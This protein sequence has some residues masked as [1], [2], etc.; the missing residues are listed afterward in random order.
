MKIGFFLIA[1]SVLF[2]FAGIKQT[3][4]EDNGEAKSVGHW[5][6]SFLP[7]IV[8]LILGLK[9]SKKAKDETD[10]LSVPVLDEEPEKELSVVPKPPI[11]E[12]VI[13]RFK[14]ASNDIRYFA[15][16][17]ELELSEWISA[18]QKQLHEVKINLS[19]I[20]IDEKTLKISVPEASPSCTLVIRD[21]DPNIL[22]R[23]AGFDMAGTSEDLIEKKFLLT[24]DGNREDRAAN[25]IY[26]MLTKCLGPITK[27]IMIDVELEYATDDWISWG[28]DY[29]NGDMFEA[30]N[31]VGLDV[32]Y[33]SL[34][35]EEKKKWNQEFRNAAIY[36]DL[37]SL[38]KFLDDDPS[39]VNEKDEYGFT[40]LHEAVGEHSVETI[41]LLLAA[42]ADVNI[43]NDDEITPLHLVAYDYIAE[44]LLDAG[45]DIESGANSV[46][47]PLH[48]HAAEPESNEVIEILLKRGA[49]KL[50]QNSN[51]ETP[52]DIAQSR[53]EFDKVR[54]FSKY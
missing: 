33:P 13:S 38:K 31:S 18:I 45:A 48:T 22:D 51:G 43:K 27:G 10:S 34:R 37:D 8:L 23:L 24:L 26:N 52:V 39:L 28:Y 1:L 3:F 11:E 9:F 49:N 4:L 17:N 40:A 12:C 35:Y 54:L 6:G 50:A 36:G 16:D 21:M 2:A 32:Q 20:E 14:P 47:T 5:V 7:C 46:G 44:A 30:F 19:F 53:Q 25:F 42:G 15:V 41:H 29:M